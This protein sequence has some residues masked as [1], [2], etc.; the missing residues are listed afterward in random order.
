[1]LYVFI[2]CPLYKKYQTIPEVEVD[3]K[4]S[5]V[6]PSNVNLKKAGNGN[7]NGK[8]IVESL[9]R[10]MTRRDTIMEDPAKVEA[11]RWITSEI[12]RKRIFE[13]L[14]KV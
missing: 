3:K 9:K 7:G 14:S 12:D 2:F 4:T 13:K 6:P 5:D 1:M 8:S 11:K 10:T